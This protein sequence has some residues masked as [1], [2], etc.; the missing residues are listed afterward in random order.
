MINSFLFCFVFDTSSTHLLIQFYE[1]YEQGAVQVESNLPCGES[2]SQGVR[3]RRLPRSCSSRQTLRRNFP[4]WFRTG[5]L[6]LENWCNE[7]NATFLNKHWDFVKSKLFVRTK[8]NLVICRENYRI[9]SLF[10]AQANFCLGQWIKWNFLRNWREGKDKCQDHV[11]LTFI[12]VVCS[13]SKNGV[14]DVFVL[15]DLGLVQVL[16]KVRRVVV[17]VRDSDT[18]ELWHWGKNWSISVQYCCLLEYV[19]FFKLFPL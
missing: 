18:D 11:I 16:V 15:V 4:V 1:K 5:F 13:N 3:P 12:F 9:F 10:K 17:L 8:C 2:R 14:L 7:R 19:M 6:K